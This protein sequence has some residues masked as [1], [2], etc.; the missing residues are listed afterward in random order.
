MS[1]DGTMARLP[2]LEPFAA[3]HK[4]PLVSIADLIHYRSQSEQLVSCMASAKL[5]TPVGEFRLYAYRNVL[6]NLEHLALVK[7]EVANRENVLVRV[8]SECATGDVFGSLRC[9]CGEQ[10]RL[11]M[12]RVQDEGTG[13]V[14]Y[15]RQEGRGIGLGHKIQA[16]HLQ[17]E[18]L[19]TVEANEKLGF[20]VDLRDYGIGAQILRDLGLS[21]IRIL[22]NNP[23]KVVSL[24]GYGLRITEQLPIA[25]KANKHNYRYLKTKQ[26]KMGHSLGGSL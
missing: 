13:V 26:E 11:A 2:E 20:P 12:Q 9:D 8:H 6:D 17:D 14:L 18:G 3:K 4:L 7:G 24:E 23:K 15:L 1:D 5:P 19:D 22:T 25:V 16:Y 21:T 10:L